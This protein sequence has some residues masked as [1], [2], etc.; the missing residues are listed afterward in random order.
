MIELISA[1][2]VNPDLLILNGISNALVKISKVYKLDQTV[3][4]SI[5]GHIKSISQRAY[6]LYQFRDAVKDDPKAVL[7]LDHIDSDLNKVI[8]ILLKLGTLKE[9]EIPIETYIRYVKSNDPELLPIVLELVDST[10][11]PENRKRTLHLIDPDADLNKIGK[12]LFPDMLDQSDA[13]L[14][15]WIE[16]PHL[17][18]T[19]I[20]LHYVLKT[21][22]IGVMKKIKWD[23]IPNSIFTKNLFN[24][25][26]QTYLNRNFLNN[27]FPTQENQPMYSI[28]E[29]TI[30]LKSVDLFHQIPGDVLTQIAQIAEEIRCE[31]TMRSL[32]KVTTAI[33]CLSSFPGKWM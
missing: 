14:E 15:Y 30:I 25:S 17:W 32:R 19:G 3:L 7:I 10:F 13:M 5:E 31:K 20:A 9:P 29:K 12:E 27:K 24:K 1:G 22:N 11:S 26:E 23:S 8:P 28:L 18:K 33:P 4:D 21:E 16:N 2:L 6:Q